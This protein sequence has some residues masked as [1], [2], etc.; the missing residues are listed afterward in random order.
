LTNLRNH[1]PT[2]GSKPPIR[3]EKE[4]FTGGGIKGGIENIVVT[5]F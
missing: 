2:L 4:K 5:R 3:D 1:T